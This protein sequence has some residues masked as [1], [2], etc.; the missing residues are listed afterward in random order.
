M[1]DEEHNMT[2]HVMAYRTLSREE[3]IGAIRAY[4]LQRK[5]RR[6][7]PERNKIITIVTVLG[8]SPGL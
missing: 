4:H 3:V 1:I 7:T 8:C 5:G 2:Y 6:K